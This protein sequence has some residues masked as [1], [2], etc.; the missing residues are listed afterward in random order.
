MPERI[1]LRRVKGWR[2]PPNAVVVSR[3]SRWGNM[4]RIGGLIRDP[5]YS[6]GPAHP[7]DGPLSPG[8][9]D[10]FAIR[11]VRDRADA[12]ALFTAYIDFH[13]DEWSPEVI[14]RELGGKDLACWCPLTEPCHRDP[15]MRI[16]NEPGVAHD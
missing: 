7:Y 13:D 6:G 8:V 4:F 16:A 9:Y 10:G 14:R 1:Q 11:R 12:V 2:L 3:P 5:G 15:L